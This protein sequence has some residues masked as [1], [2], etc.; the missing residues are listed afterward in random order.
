MRS[1][2]LRQG[3]LRQGRR[4][5]F[6]TFSKVCPGPPSGRGDVSEPCCRSPRGERSRM[7]GR[8]QA[9]K[10]PSM[11]RA[12]GIP[13][14]A[15][16]LPGLS[17][18]GSPTCRSGRACRAMRKVRRGERE[19]PAWGD[20]MSARTAMPVATRKAADNDSQPMTAFYVFAVLAVSPAEGSRCGPPRHRQQGRGDPLSPL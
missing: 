2:M 11:W 4:M 10:K 9:T 3:R 14:G 13:D 12:F 7:S 5:P 16:R 19:P 8:P 1:V 6:R 18:G 15:D 20:R 17:P